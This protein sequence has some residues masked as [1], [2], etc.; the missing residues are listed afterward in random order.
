MTAQAFARGWSAGDDA[1]A[2]RLTDDPKAAAAVLRANR[3]GLDG[4]TVK[5]A[6]SELK[7]SG[8]TATAKLTLR[9]QIP[10]I[11]PWASHSTLRRSGDEWRVR[12]SPKTVHPK[13]DDETRLGTMAVAK[14]RGELLDRDRRPLVRERPVVRVG[15]IAGKVQRPGSRRG[16]WPTCS[17]WTPGRWSARSGAGASSSSSTRSSCVPRTT[18][19]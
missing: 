1:A 4:A 19:A 6:P 3:R 2:A 17:T 9:W 7:E 12:W 14:P 8:D 16:G 15:A 5:V 18:V 10:R 11:G 13:L